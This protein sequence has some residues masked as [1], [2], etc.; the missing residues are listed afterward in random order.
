[1]GIGVE[2]FG[3]R[4]SDIDAGVA[5][6]ELEHATKKQPTNSINNT[7]ATKRLMKDPLFMELNCVL[8]K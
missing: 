1:M 2:L 4:W 5:A 7:V 6:E 3:S 8:Y